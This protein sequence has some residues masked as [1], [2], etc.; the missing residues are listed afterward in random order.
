MFWTALML[1][2]ESRFG[3]GVSAERVPASS[4][5]CASKRSSGP[6]RYD[7]G[8]MC[9]RRLAGRIAVLLVALVALSAVA[10]F[11]RRS[12]E[13]VVPRL[14]GM[15]LDRAERALSNLRLRSAGGASVRFAPVAGPSHA[16]V[17]LLSAG[18]D[19]DRP[20]TAQSIPAGLPVPPGSVVELGTT[21][22][23]RGAHKGGSVIFPM[24]FAR[25]EIGRDDRTLTLQIPSIDHCAAL[26]HIDLTGSR[27][28]LV[29]TPFA[30]EPVAQPECRGGGG[31]SLQLVLARALAGRVVLR[32]PPSA[33]TGGLFKIRTG[34]WDEA[35]YLPS[36]RAVA[37]YFDHSSNCGVLAGST[38]K[39]TGREI[40]ITL[41]VGDLRSNRICL[42]G[43]RPDAAVVRLAAPV[44]QRRVVD[45]FRAP[46]GRAS[47][48]LMLCCGTEVT[49][50]GPGGP[51]GP[52]GPR[53]REVPRRLRL[54]DGAGNVVAAALV[55]PGRRFTL[56]APIGHYTLTSPDGC[57]S[58]SGP[59]MI[60]RKRATR[61]L[62]RCPVP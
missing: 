49:R 9:W 56:T 20:V 57:F 62:M 11:A 13:V 8:I 45:D 43:L 35:S 23:F 41:T 44:G 42:A 4:G 22:P 61:V 26:D 19:L 54:R 60:A 17:V 55:D 21:G 58:F 30:T 33:P 18:A 37:V 39:E 47:G 29:A 12:K 53:P 52:G 2:T 10:A 50:V 28:S 16:G 24:R 51:S 1:V 59:V 7:H 6:R 31:L 25:Y 48:G 15:R 5:D 27:S 14:S 32:F 34:R 3:S 40:R 36:S 38:V 46:L